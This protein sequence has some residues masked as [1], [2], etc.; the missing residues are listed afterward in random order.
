MHR[1]RRQESGG[2]G[3]IEAMLAALV[4]ALGMMSLVRLQ[5]QFF[6]SN[7]NS[8]IYT[9]ALRFAQEKLEAVRSAASQADLQNLGSGQDSCDPQQTGSFCAG[10]HLA[11]QRSWGLSPCANPL[12]CQK[13]VSKVSWQTVRGVTQDVVLSSYISGIAPIQA[14]VLLSKAASP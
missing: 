12:P 1:L 3:L 10:L 14:G 9:E 13:I 8:L 6:Y 2:F 7:K 5:E 11:L 4:V